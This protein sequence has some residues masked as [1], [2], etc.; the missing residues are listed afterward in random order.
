MNVRLDHIGIAIEELAPTLGFFRDVLGLTVE[1][2][3]DVPSHQVRV[4]FLPAGGAKL[5]LLEATAEDSAV[6]KYLEKRGAGLHHIAFC[7][8]D[9]RAALAH[10]KALGVRLIDEQPR[11]GAEGAL[12]A[13]VHPSSAHGVLVELKQSAAAESL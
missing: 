4:H 9:I 5:E 6:A 7:V 8:D 12:V 2:T 13:F 1:S 3:E 10:L 11:P